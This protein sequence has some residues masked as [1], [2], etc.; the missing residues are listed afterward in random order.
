MLFSYGLSSAFLPVH[1]LIL[2]QYSTLSLILK[3]SRFCLKFIIQN[4]EPTNV[5][6]SD[7]GQREP[8]SEYSKFH[9][10]VHWYRYLGSSLS[11]YKKLTLVAERLVALFHLPGLEPIFRSSFGSLYSSILWVV[12]PTRVALCLLPHWIAQHCD[13]FKLIVTAS[14]S[15]TWKW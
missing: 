13:F 12:S 14:R 9:M 7:I 5:L 1:W 2:D 3:E 11:A 15:S 4:S 6:K 8:E 10:L